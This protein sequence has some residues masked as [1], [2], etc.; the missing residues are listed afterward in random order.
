VQSERL[1]TRF[2]RDLGI[3]H[4]IL[5]A[6][7][8]GG[9]AGPELAAAVCDAG[10][11]GFLGMGGLPARAIREHIRETRRRTSKPFGAGLLLPLLEGGEVE[12]CVEERVPVLLLFWGDVAPHV[13]KAKRAGI[14]VFAQVGSVDEARAAAAAGVDAIVAQGYEAGGHVR[15]NTSLVTLIPAVCEAVAP[16]PVIAAGG[17]ATGRGLVAA[18]GLGAE[19]VLMGTR[20]VASDES[21]AADEYKQRIVRA[22]AEDTVHTML[23]DIGWP[24]AAH[25]VIRNKAIDE[26]EAA[27][28]PPSG[29]RPGEGTIIGQMRIG[30]QMTDVPRY[31]VGSPMAGF[32][33]DLDYTVL[34]AGESCGLVNDIKPAAAIVRDVVAEAEALLR[35]PRS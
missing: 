9:T 6:P 25:R 22:R 7:L 18:L 33:G 24:D 11:L 27:G 28:R 32:Q 31:F 5:S 12:A 2:C 34:Y 17:I 21:R 26:W 20:F 14:R 30:N 16:L 10:G 13:E 29:Q 23:F 3:D 19:A 8:G 35:E 1:K 4:P 15:G